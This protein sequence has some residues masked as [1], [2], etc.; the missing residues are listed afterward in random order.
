MNKLVEGDIKARARQI[1][2][3]LSNVLESAGSKLENI[4]KVNI[5]LTDMA[6]FQAVNEVYVEMMPQPM[7]ARTC[8]AVHQLPFYT[9]IEI[10][11]SAFIDGKSE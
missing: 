4:I 1:L 6:N 7:P 11:C 5:F 8:V 3:N 2:T 9:D 10:E